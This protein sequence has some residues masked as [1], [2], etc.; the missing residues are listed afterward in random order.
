MPRP[1]TDAL[2][3]QWIPHFEPKAFRC[4]EQIRTLDID[5]SL[6]IENALLCIADV[7]DRVHVCVPV[8]PN[9]EICSPLEADV[10]PPNV[11]GRRGHYVA[12]AINDPPGESCDK[13]LRRADDLKQSIEQQTFANDSAIGLDSQH[14][15]IRVVEQ[16]CILRRPKIAWIG[17]VNATDVNES[18]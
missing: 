15:C 9:P 4:S 8:P 2:L 17:A 13:I 7:R 11:A 12:I 1:G 14:D 5:A 6:H 10:I 16:E 3:C 18:H